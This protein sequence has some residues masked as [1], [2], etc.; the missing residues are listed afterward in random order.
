MIPS[1]IYVLVHDKEAEWKPGPPT[2]YD[3]DGPPACLGPS[4]YSSGVS[5]GNNA[6]HSYGSSG[7]RGTTRQ[8]PDLL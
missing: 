4:A 7:E 3:H 2:D 5:H 8:C 6:P 1:S